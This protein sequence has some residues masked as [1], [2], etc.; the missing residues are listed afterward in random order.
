MNTIVLR[1]ADFLKNIPPFSFLTDDEQI[2]VAKSIKVEYFDV[3]EDIFPY[4]GKIHSAFYLVKEGAIGLYSEED[5]LS[6]ECDE[7]DIFGLRAL[8]RQDTYKLA[9]RAIEE[10]IVY[11]IPSEIYDQIISKNAEAVSFI[12]Q[13]F[14]N[15]LIRVKEEVISKPRIKEAIIE[16]ESTAKYSKIRLLVQKIL[17]SNLP[18]RS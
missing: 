18:H 1:I 15:N 8:I 6:D 14:A 11:A 4:D 2:N 13:N 9:A 10:T 5:R 12:A 17:V 16:D 3:D 7:G